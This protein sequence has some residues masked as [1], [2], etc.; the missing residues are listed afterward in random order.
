[1]FT[2]T[3]KVKR[4]IGK[5]LQSDSF[6]N[7]SIL[8]ARPNCKGGLNSLSGH[9]SPLILLYHIRFLKPPSPYMDLDKFHQATTAITLR[10]I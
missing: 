6:I 2:K 7:N 8:F 10:P 3:K 9:S 4:F 1:M 5:Y